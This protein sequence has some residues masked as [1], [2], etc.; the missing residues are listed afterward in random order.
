M[1]IFLPVAGISVN[2]YLLMGAGAGLDSLALVTILAAYEASLND[3]YG[4]AVV[5]ADERAMS[6][7]R[8]PFR[9]VQSLV[10]YAEELL[11]DAGKV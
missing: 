6:R 11:R 9:D 7:E 10:A 4:A 5:L 8:S 2:I 3:R 1:S